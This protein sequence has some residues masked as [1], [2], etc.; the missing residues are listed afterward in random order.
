M[1]AT[2]PSGRRGQVLALAMLAIGLLALWLGIG[3]PLCA[4]YAQR[5]SRLDE[6]R[7]LVAHTAAL[8]A[9]LPDLMRRAAPAAGGRASDTDALAAAELQQR[10]EQ[11]AA[12]A[13]TEITSV[14]TLPAEQGNAIKRIRLRVA[15]QASWPKLLALLSAIETYSPPL[16]TDDLDL[17]TASAQKADGQNGDAPTLQVQ[18]SVIA[19]R[20]GSTAV[21]GP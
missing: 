18:F 5:A 11:L 2:L 19:L 17:H 7:L 9:T 12:N 10:L 13:G 1:S 8:A 16:L 20:S 21:Q 15:L 3:G 6:Q 14:E 4:W